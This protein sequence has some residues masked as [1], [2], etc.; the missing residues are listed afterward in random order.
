[1]SETEQKRTRRK[2][3]HYSWSTYIY[4]VL[5]QVHPDSGLRSSSN[6]MMNDIIN[7]LTNTIA[8]TAVL[9]ATRSKKVTV[10]ARMIQSAVRILLPTALTN[11]AVNEGTKA[12]TIYEHGGPGSKDHKISRNRRA[13]LQFSVSKMESILRSHS[14]KSI[15]RVSDSAPVYLAAVVEYIVAELLE[16]SGNA[17]RNSKL[18]RITPRNIMTAIHS[19][20]EFNILFKKKGILGTGV[21]PNIHRVLLPK[22]HRSSDYS[23]NEHAKPYYD[24]I[25]EA[26]GVDGLKSLQVI[27][28]HVEENRH[29]AYRNSTLLRVLVNAV[30]KGNLVQ[31]KG[32]YKLSTKIRAKIVKKAQ[33]QKGGASDRM[34]RGVNRIRDSIQ[35]ITKPAIRRLM[36]RAGVKSMSSLVYEE[37]RGVLQHNLE[38]LLE[39]AV[40][41][42]AHRRAK[43]IS[44]KDYKEAA[45]ELGLESISAK[46]HPKVCGSRRRRRSSKEQAGG[47]DDEEFQNQEDEELDSSDDDD[48]QNNNQNGG[49]DDDDDEDQDDN[50]NNNNQNGGWDD[51]D[52]DDEDENQHNNNQ[53]NNYLNNNQNGGWYDQDDDDE[54]ENNQNANNQNDN[55]QN[56]N[57]QNDNNQNGGAKK[58]YRHKPGYWNISNIRKHQK[59]GCLLFP[60]AAMSRLIREVA[61]KYLSDVRHSKT[62]IVYAHALL[63]HNLTSLAEAANLLAISAKR[64]IVSPRDIHLAR[65]LRGELD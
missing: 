36:H 35:G 41:L 39:N 20:P 22:P 56:N 11:H 57:N 29:P 63:E 25:V 59:T 23:K 37:M 4:R 7:Q 62:S 51:Q 15:R 44:Y 30:K 19:D 46:N 52:D 34:G 18:S 5:K 16:L 42:M 8:A 17:A 48:D 43:T 9:M 2:K 6:D 33:R 21:L 27:K 13:K 64:S 53:N 55:N 32:S 1:M 38:I 49:W 10:N 28:R 50:Q 24:L 60:H 45:H 3:R 14:T 61:D 47:W 31:K 65:D 58:K 54:H 40:T 12:V 26:I